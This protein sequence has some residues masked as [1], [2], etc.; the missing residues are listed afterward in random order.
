MAGKKIKQNVAAAIAESLG[1]GSFRTKNLDVERQV[2][3]HCFRKPI[4]LQVITANLTVDDFSDVRHKVFYKYIASS[5]EQGRYPDP[6][7]CLA[8]AKRS[9]E[10]EIDPEDYESGMRDV[11]ELSLIHI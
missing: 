2:L 6:S 5:N 10:F 8:V 4:N 7:I 3:Y 9:V 1:D 11:L